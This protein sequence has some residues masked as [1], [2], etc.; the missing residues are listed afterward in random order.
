MESQASVLLVLIPSS[1]KWEDCVTKSNQNKICAKSN[2]R[3]GDPLG[4]KGAADSTKNHMNVYNRKNAERAQL[5]KQ[6]NTN[7]KK[8]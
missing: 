3:W 1:D 8:N 5:R 4:N 6:V 7:L 2:M